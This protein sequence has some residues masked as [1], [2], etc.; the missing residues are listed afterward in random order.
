M[1]SGVRPQRLPHT[2]NGKKRRPGAGRSE[3]R[4]DDG[5][6]AWSA[7]FG[8]SAAPQAYRAGVL[9]VLPQEG[10]VVIPGADSASRWLSRGVERRL[11]EP[12]FG[13]QAAAV[14]AELR[15]DRLMSGAIPNLSTTPDLLPI[16]LVWI[17]TGT[18]WR[19]DWSKLR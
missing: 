18:R 12:S 4:I 13:R 2:L 19:I 14:E 11:A 3:R 16:P 1:K 5:S 17:K 15:R 6:S 10:E 8:S 9:R 7:P